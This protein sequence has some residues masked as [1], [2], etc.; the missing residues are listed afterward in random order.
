MDPGYSR[1]NKFIKLLLVKLADG[2]AVVD[3]LPL[4]YHLRPPNAPTYQENYSIHCDRQ[5]KE[6]R[7]T[8]NGQPSGELT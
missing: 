7:A 5:P 3:E 8:V 4:D 6:P 2:K 1:S